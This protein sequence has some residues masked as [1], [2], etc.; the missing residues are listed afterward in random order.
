ME[1]SH[2]SK[3]II[4]A[5]SMWPTGCHQCYCSPSR[6]TEDWV[7]DKETEPREGGCF[8]RESSK[9]SSQNALSVVNEVI[10]K[11][12]SC[13]TGG[14]WTVLC[15]LSQERRWWLHREGLGDLAS[16]TRARRCGL[17]ITQR[18]QTSRRGGPRIQ[19]LCA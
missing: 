16:M 13:P 12:F 3:S 15:I 5:Y 10:L 18:L 8:H 1:K 19:P 2:S 14:R 4:R 7:S 17:Y 9:H 11:V 6:G